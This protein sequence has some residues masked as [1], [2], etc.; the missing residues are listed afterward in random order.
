MIGEQA[1]H[2]KL[3]A[4]ADAFGAANRTF[5]A[6]RQRSHS[7]HHLENDLAQQL[8]RTARRCERGREVVVRFRLGELRRLGG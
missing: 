5:D 3:V 8:E 1:N 6:I 7:L 4:D 2:H